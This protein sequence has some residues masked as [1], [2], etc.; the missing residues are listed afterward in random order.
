MPRPGSRAA[1]YR[2]GIGLVLALAYLLQTAGLLFI[3]PTNSEF[4]TGIFVVFAPLAHRL[5]FG[6]RFSRP[7]LV[8][9]GLSLLGM[10]LLAGA[11]APTRHTRG[12]CSPC[13]AP[14]LWGST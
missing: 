11:A 13:S 10:I 4:I 12:T 7:V 9:V 3:S 8:A 1:P 2:V 6:A 14:A 5:F